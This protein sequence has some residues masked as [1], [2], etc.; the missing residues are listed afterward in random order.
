[1]NEL[2][3]NNINRRRNFRLGRS[4]SIEFLLFLARLTLDET[5]KILSPPRAIRRRQIAQLWHR[6]GSFYWAPPPPLR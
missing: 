5:R 3:N 2:V 6:L 1:M 4:L